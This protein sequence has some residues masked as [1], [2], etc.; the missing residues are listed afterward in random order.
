MDE[1]CCCPICG[2]IIDYWQYHRNDIQSKYRGYC[3]T[4]EN[5][6]LNN[7]KECQKEKTE[8]LH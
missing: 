8:Y 3:Y 5:N 7:D 6:I 2:R 1:L 4:C